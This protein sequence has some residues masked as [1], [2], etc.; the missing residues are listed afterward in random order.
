M[1]QKK[2]DPWQPVQKARPY[3]QNNQ[4]KRWKHGSISECLPCKSKALISMASNYY[5]KK[6]A[7]GI[8]QE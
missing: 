8:A 4:S 5:C 2:K 6:G 3:I 7:K 1:K